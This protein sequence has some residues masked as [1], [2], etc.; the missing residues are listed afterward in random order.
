MRAAYAKGD[1][2]IA[3]LEGHTIA[4]YCWVGFSPVHHLDGVWVE[5]APSV[6]WTYKSLV[7]PSH[8]G[9]GLAPMLYRF[10]DALSRERGR[11]TSVVCIE[12]HNV[13]SARAALNAGYAMP[14]TPRGCAARI[15]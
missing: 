13:P 10:A 4:G 5:T 14:A 2:C 15:A 8:R 7:R 1:L 11:T 3:A 9:R 12:D 6:A